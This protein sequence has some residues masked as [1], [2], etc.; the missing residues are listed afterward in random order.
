MAERTVIVSDLGGEELPNDQHVKLIVEHPDYQ[1]PLELDSSVEEAEKFQDTALRIVTVTIHA[2]NVPVRKV[3]VETK[4]IDKLFPKVN[5]D[6]VL[7]GARKAELATPVRRTPGRPA[8]TPSAPAGDKIDYTSPEN[9]GK[10]HRGRITEA[11]KDW[12]RA[13]RDMASYNR[14]QQTGKPIDFD[15]PAEVKR[16]SL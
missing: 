2:P 10:L 1:M 7:Q 3:R 12:V 15:D 16:Y 5:F 14:E 8:R 11:E 9:A 4:T 13:N 6:E